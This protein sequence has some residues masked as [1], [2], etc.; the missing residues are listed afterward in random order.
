MPELPEV[1]TTLRGLEPHCL[2]RS[3]IQIDVNQPKLRWPIPPQIQLL[4]NARI[5]AMQRRA[6]YL[7]MSTDKGHMIWHLG[8]SGSMRLLPNQ[9]PGVKHEH[10]KITFENKTSLRY[11]DP[12][13][14]GALLLTHDD[15]LLHP[16]ISPLGPEPL[17][18]DFHADYLWQQCKNRKTAI[19]NVIMH[20]HIVVGV[21][22]IYACESLFMSGIN[23]KT[24]ALRISRKRIQALVEAIKMVLQQ[25][26]EQGGTTLKD[27]TQSDGKP[28]YFTQSLKVYANAQNCVQCG[29]AIKRIT[30]GQRTTY[31]CPSCQH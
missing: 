19:K 18:E 6:K 22:N 28:G 25:A 4:K 31:Y 26:I 13:R 11:R 7:I 10:V 23:P 21:G 20:S 9:D 2:N 3:I 12:R 14:F 27:F 1:E 24:S 5:T 17:S 8:M 15:P 16:L 29:H 30:Q